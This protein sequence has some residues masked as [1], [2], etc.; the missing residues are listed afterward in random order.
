MLTRCFSRMERELPPGFAGSH[1]PYMLAWYTENRMYK[2]AYQLLFR[3]P[4]L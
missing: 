1:I 2:D 3:S 4:W